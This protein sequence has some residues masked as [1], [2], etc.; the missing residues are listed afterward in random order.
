MMNCETSNKSGFCAR[1]AR[2]IRGYT[3]KCAPS[4][5]ASCEMKIV[6][7]V[8]PTTASTSQPFQAGFSIGGGTTGPNVV[9]TT[10]GSATLGTGACGSVPCNDCGSNCG[11]S[12]VDRLVPFRL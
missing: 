4:N 9:E 8:R 5:R 6:A 2:E 10:K 7:T 1:S 12:E 11:L 3:M